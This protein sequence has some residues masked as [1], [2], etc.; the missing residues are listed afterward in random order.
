[1]RALHNAYRLARLKA[2]GRRFSPEAWVRRAKRLICHAGMRFFELIHRLRRGRPR[3]LEK[4][5]PARLP[6]TEPM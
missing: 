6:V 1:V 4:R 2:E 5:E 3:V